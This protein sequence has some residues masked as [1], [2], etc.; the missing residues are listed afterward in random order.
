MIFKVVI[1]YF[2]F[3]VIFVV[4]AQLQCQFQF[5]SVCELR[6]YKHY[7]IN[8]EIQTECSCLNSWVK[9]FQSRTNSSFLPARPGGGLVWPPDHLSWILYRLSIHNHLEKIVDIYKSTKSRKVWHVRSISKIFFIHFYC[10]FQNTGQQ[11]KI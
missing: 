7:C 6:R 5:G 8:Y 3:F 2:V 1:L 10:F 11:S 4:F 9:K